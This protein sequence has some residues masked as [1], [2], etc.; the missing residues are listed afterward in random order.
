MNKYNVTKLY[1]LIFVFLQLL[2]STNVP[3]KNLEAPFFIS[4]KKIVVISQFKNLT[5]DLTLNWLETG[6]T[7][8]LLTQLA[9]FPNTVTVERRLLK[10]AM[11]EINLKGV[12]L[13]EDERLINA[14]QRLRAD[15]II[16][17]QFSLSRNNL[18]IQL[19]LLHVNSKHPPKLKLVHGEFPND[20]SA[21]MD[22]ISL[23]LILEIHPEFDLT[24]SQI[25]KRELVLP[26]AADSYYKGLLA[27]ENGSY[28][29]A[30]KW[31]IETIHKDVLFSPAHNLLVNTFE[32]MGTVGEA[33]EFYKNMVKKNPKNY[34]VHNYLGNAL[35]AANSFEE[36]QD[37]Y[38]KAISLNAN[39]APPYNNLGN[40]CKQW[41]MM[42]RAREYYEKALKL[43]IHQPAIVYNNL[44]LLYSDNNQFDLAEK[45]YRKA[46]NLKHLPFETLF[47]LGNLYL[48]KKNYEKAIQYYLGTLKIYPQ[49]EAA[50][51]NLGDA[52]SMSGN[53]IK[54][55]RIWEKLYEVNSKN[56]GVI[57]KLAG[58][59][60]DMNDT[61][62]AAKYIRI[63]FASDSSSAEIWKLKGI[64]AIK[65]NNYLAAEEAL[66]K[67]I[68]L[69]S[70]DWQTYLYLGQLYFQNKKY[71][72]AIKPLE[73]S[74]QILNKRKE[75][76]YYI[77]QEE[78]IW[79]M[80]AKS[81][82][83][84]S[85]YDAALNAYKKLIELNPKNMAARFGIKIIENMT[86]K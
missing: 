23:L 38:L 17:G 63:A 27:Y 21:L 24:S 18:S 35:M 32:R 64:L 53:I 55:R 57:V 41:G 8:M 73:S 9:S 15:W 80:V 37:E 12:S 36:A 84:L 82:E 49:F 60:I 34:V 50:L 86:R 31:L 28:R 71:F 83:K 65:E 25:Q 67:S 58:I 22:Q 70:D 44:G 20:L 29:R 39:F 19:Q 42:V 61:L 14:A 56:E 78:T 43:Q 1:I 5:G 66:K 7:D 26:T 77:D 81:F 51:Q 10:I 79:F 3:S 74:E 47:N 46:I 33:V 6:L 69:N 45:Y 2:S 75:N 48:R 40:I 11:S 59:C 72:A 54:A 85:H 68:K 76:D 4:N 30:T 52:Y 62:N 13:P 16:K